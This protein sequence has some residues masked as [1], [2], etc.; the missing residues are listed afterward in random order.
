MVAI[1]CALHIVSQGKIHEVRKTSWSQVN[2]LNLSIMKRG[3][4]HTPNK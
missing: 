1:A 4:P 2:A 3:Y